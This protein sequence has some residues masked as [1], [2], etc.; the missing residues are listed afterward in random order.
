MK[1]INELLLQCIMQTSVCDNITIKQKDKLNKTAEIRIRNGSNLRSR[2]IQN[3]K[4]VERIV[5]T[6]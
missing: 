3:I 2:K 1:I 5:K 4:R 6:L